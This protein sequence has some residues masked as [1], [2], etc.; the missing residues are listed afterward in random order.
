MSA[1]P[2]E[3]LRLLSIFHYVLAGLA[4]LFSLFPLIHVALGLAMIA[5]RFPPHGAGPA[6]PAFIGWLLV[7]VGASFIVAGL[8]YAVL[9]AVAGR[10]LARARNWTFCV[11]MAALSCALFPFGTV[12]GVLTIVYLAKPE[13]KELFEPRPTTFAGPAGPP[14]AGPGDAGAARPS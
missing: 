3:T 13:V 8:G 2:R 1:A 7:L 14:G 5:G 11:V 12:L 4:A 9:V 6:A 10:F